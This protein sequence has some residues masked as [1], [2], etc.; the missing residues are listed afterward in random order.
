A[1]RPVGD[2]AEGYD[3][4]AWEYYGDPGIVVR[5]VGAASEAGRHAVYIDGL[6]GY[7]ERGWH[8]DVAGE[9]EIGGREAWR[10]AVTMPDGLGYDA[11]IDAQT[12]LLIAERK[13]APIHAFGAKVT[14]EE[15]IGDYRDVDGVL[16]P[17]EHKEVEIASGRV[18]NE[19]HWKSITLN[20]DL[21]RAAFSPPEWK[22]TPVQE[23]IAQIFAER[24]DANA[25]MWTYRDFR[26][27]HPDAETDAAIQAVGYQM[28]K[29]GDLH[30]AAVLLEQNATDHPRSA[31]AA[32]GLGRA[33][34]AGGDCQRAAR[35][36]RRAIALD[37]AYKR[38]A[39]ALQKLECR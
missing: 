12:W 3:G 30:P 10:L 16:F 14:S 9:E 4:S 21:D 36:F 5:T 27:A 17:F 31:T 34:A 37:P 19:M 25:V 38:A 2:F 8:V 32:F 15:R 39:E 29:M 11:F 24:T 23:L 35:E 6:L 28:L 26:G 22:R 1:E 20:H 7:R 13:A 33:A 18:L